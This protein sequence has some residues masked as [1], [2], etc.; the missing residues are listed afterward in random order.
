MAEN[1]L[2]QQA[3]I[4][5]SNVPSTR[6]G[7]RVDDSAVSSSPKISSTPHENHLNIRYLKYGWFNHVKPPKVVGFQWIGFHGK[8]LT[9]NHPFS[10]EK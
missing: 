7:R 5:F 3:N 1:H 6:C 10:H 2:F 8:I 9:G 4:I